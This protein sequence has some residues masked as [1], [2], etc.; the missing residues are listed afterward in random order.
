MHLTTTTAKKVESAMIFTVGS[1]V[2]PVVKTFSTAA[3]SPH[4]APPA[5]EPALRIITACSH[6]IDGE[7]PSSD[8]IICSSELSS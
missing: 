4:C 7:S 5:F 6:K 3:L 1:C 8:N 2:E